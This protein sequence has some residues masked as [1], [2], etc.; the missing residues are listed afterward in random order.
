[1]F[2]FYGKGGYPYVV[3]LFLQPDAS[4]WGV[5]FLLRTGDAEFSRRMVT[6]KWRGGF[7]PDGFTVQ[8]ARVWKDGAV[9]D[10]PEEADVFKLW[11]MEFV[12]PEDRG[13]RVT[14]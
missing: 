2:T 14:V 10:T 11:N 3:D 5:N 13:E 8:D 12:Q 6:P 4:T 9:L 1:M 7:M